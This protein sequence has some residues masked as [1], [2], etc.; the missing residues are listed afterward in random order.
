[1][2][3]LVVEDERN[4]ADAICH[5]LEGAGYNA[6]AAYDGKAGLSYARSGL[7]DAMILDVMLPGM[8]GFDVV[9]ELRHEGNPLPVLMLT[10]RTSTTDK[11]EGLDAGA[12]DYMTKPFE[13]PELLA[14]LRALTRRKG[15]VVIDEVTFGD[16]KLDLNTHDLTCENRT[17]HLSG[18]EFEVMRLLMGSTQRVVSKQDL[19]ARVWGTENN[20]SENSVEAYISF[21]RKKLSHVHSKVQITTLR[22]LGYR[23]EVI[24]L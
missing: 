9:H 10:A 6:E 19:L 17:V 22:M 21:L 24:E 1:M 12:D 15:D 23:L 8:N 3:I 14:R 11:V 2:N 18:K 13:A 20:A 7:Y 5:I 4:L 16:I